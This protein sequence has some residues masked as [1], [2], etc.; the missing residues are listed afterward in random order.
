M[1]TCHNLESPAKTVF[2]EE[3]YSLPWP[4]DVSVNCDAAQYRQHHSLGWA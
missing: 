3:F 2:V 4:M 1:S